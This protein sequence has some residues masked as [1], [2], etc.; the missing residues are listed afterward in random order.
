[1]VEVVGRL[2][3]LVGFPRGLAG[4]GAGEQPLPLPLST[5]CTPRVSTAMTKTRT[6]SRSVVRGRTA[7]AAP[8]S[9]RGGASGALVVADGGITQRA[10]PV[11]GRAGEAVAAEHV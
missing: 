1:M 11:A 9:M 5:H 7:Y 3:H 10:Q 6:G 2:S 8:T 4:R